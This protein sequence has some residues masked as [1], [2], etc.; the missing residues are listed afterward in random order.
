MKVAGKHTDML[1]VG[2]GDSGASEHLHDTSMNGMLHDARPSHTHYAAAVGYIHG[3]STGKLKLSVPNL[4]G[5]PGVPDWVD[6]TITTTTAKGLSSNLWSLE[7]SFEDQGY[8]VHMWLNRV[9]K[10]IYLTPPF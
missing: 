7:A 5:L 6:M 10:P 1:Q 4:E 8:D 9:K 3:D 2:I